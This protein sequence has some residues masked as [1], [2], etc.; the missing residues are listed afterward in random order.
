M[1][2]NENWFIMADNCHSI[3]HY[4][5]FFSPSWLLGFSLP[6]HIHAK[7]NFWQKESLL[8]FYQGL[9]TQPSLSQVNA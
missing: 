3:V 6:F 1:S 9:N 4:A 8:W 2:Q 5:L 7:I